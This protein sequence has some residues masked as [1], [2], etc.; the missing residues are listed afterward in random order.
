[1]TRR[2][3]RLGCRADVPGPAHAARTDRV[4]VGPSNGV[5]LLLRVSLTIPTGEAGAE[6]P[7]ISADAT[8]GPADPVGQRS[9]GN[10]AATVGCGLL[11]P[12][13]L[14]RGAAL[15]ATVP[16]A[17]LFFVFQR[18]CVRGAS[19]GGEKGGECLNDHRNG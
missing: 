9:A 15:P 1:M 17:V 13:V 16:V 4:G 5:G 14:K 3:T 12:G 2:W 19:E 11:A 8:V 18:Y 6:L 7:R 10:L